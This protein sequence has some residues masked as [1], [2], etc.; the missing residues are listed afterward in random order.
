MSHMKRIASAS[1]LCSLAIAIGCQSTSPNNNLFPATEDAGPQPAT[2]FTHYQVIIDPSFTSDEQ[3]DI[4]NAANTWMDAVPTH[5][6]VEIATVAGNADCQNPGTMC[7]SPTSAVQYVFVDEAGTDIPD[8]DGGGNPA[9]VLGWTEFNDSTGESTVTINGRASVVGD[10]WF[11]VIAVH[12]MGHCQGLIHHQNPINIMDAFIGGTTKLSPD[13]IAQWWS[14]RTTF[15]NGFRPDED[16]SLVS[17]ATPCGP[18][19]M[20][21][22]GSLPACSEDAAYSDIPPPPP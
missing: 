14:L 19:A 2:T 8:P 3:S 22:C 15:A 13:D 1:V 18:Y 21:G 11:T 16:A 20:C 17:V 4:W 9:T 12:E 10:V 6:A 5:F 7:I